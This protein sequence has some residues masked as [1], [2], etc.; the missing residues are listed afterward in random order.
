MVSNHK[1]ATHLSGDH[2]SES[3]FP[4]CKMDIKSCGE[5]VWH[6][7]GEAGTILKDLSP[8][9]EAEGLRLGRNLSVCTEWG[10]CVCFCHGGSWIW[11]IFLQETAFPSPSKDWLLPKVHQRHF[12]PGENLTKTAGVAQGWPRWEVGIRINTSP[13]SMWAPAREGGGVARARNA[14]WFP[15]PPCLAFSLFP[16]VNARAAV[17]V[18]CTGAVVCSKQAGWVFV[19]GPYGAWEE[20]KMRRFFLTV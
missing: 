9:G 8:A 5:S 17:A 2:L 13:N 18:S 1:S 4:R 19:V 15:T 7:W 11:G 16:C 20:M 12:Q 3:Q 14:S 6:P 10:V